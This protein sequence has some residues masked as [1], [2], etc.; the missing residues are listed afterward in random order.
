MQQLIAELTNYQNAIL[1][2]VTWMG[3]EVMTP[4]VRAVVMNKKRVK[5]R[6]ALYNLQ[7]YGKRV[8]G[9]LWCSGLVWIP[10][11][12]PALCERSVVEGVEALTP[13]GCQTVFTRV[14]LGVILGGLLSSGHWAGAIAFRKL[15]GKKKKVWV[16]CVNCDEKVQVESLDDRCPK[17]NDPPHEVTSTTRMG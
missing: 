7:K 9:I 2:F 17:C 11:A 16:K 3:I 4:L 8:A 5:Y 1:M 13:E 10:Y 12:Q 6:L 14:A 15:T